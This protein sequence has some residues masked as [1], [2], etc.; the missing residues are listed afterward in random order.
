MAVK[1]VEAPSFWKSMVVQALYIYDGSEDQLSFLLQKDSGCNRMTCSGC[2]QNFCW[3]CMKIL[4]QEDPYKHFKTGCR[5]V[6]SRVL[7]KFGWT[8]SS[9]LSV[10]ID[11]VSPIFFF[12]A[13]LQSIVTVILCSTLYSTS[14][15]YILEILPHNLSYILQATLASSK[16]SLLMIFC[17]YSF[18]DCNLL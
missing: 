7:E 10:I 2:K 16:W 6:S 5:Y 3:L 18:A 4:S 15:I 9:E 12:F 11:H 17:V 1:C 14:V 8:S 13:Q